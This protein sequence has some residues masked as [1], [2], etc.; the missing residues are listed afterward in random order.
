MNNGGKTLLA[1]LGGALAGAAAGLLL[2]PK[3]GEEVRKK[4]SEKAKN[5]SG[6]LS[7]SWEVGV[8]KV[9]EYAGSAKSEAKSYQN[10]FN[11]PTG[12]N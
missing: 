6:D 8:Q 12:K 10:D 1:L 2:A 9:K 3:K 11:S 4:I 7:Q 5:L